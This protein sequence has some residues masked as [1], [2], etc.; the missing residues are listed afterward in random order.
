[1]LES[2]GLSKDRRRD[3]ENEVQALLDDGAIDVVPRANYQRLRDTA[4]RRVPRDERDWPTV[5]LAIS[6][7]VAI[8]TADND[9]LGCG[10][11][12]WT[13]ETLIAELRSR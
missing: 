6:L 10:C 7:N 3:L 2:R 4:L 9:F 11:P 5:A 1:M 13:V 12:T 8:L